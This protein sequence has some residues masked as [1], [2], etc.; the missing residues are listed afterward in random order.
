MPEHNAERTRAIFEQLLDPKFHN[1]TATTDDARYRV[2]ASNDTA[3]GQRIILHCHDVV[4]EKNHHALFEYHHGTG[5]LRLSYDV[6]DTNYMR[7]FVSAHAALPTLLAAMRSF[8]R[9]ALAENTHVD[10]L[11]LEVMSMLQKP[12]DDAT[13]SLKTAVSEHLRKNLY[14]TNRQAHEDAAGMN[15]ED[16]FFKVNGIDPD[17][18]YTGP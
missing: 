4:A 11:P 8:V 9:W 13:P 16:S 6:G 10:V 18:P 1:F 14:R 15:L 12:G 7:L 5:K 2:R 17:A 3:S